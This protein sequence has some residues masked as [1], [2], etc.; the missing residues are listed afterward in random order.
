MKAVLSGG[1][2]GGALEQ[3][4]TTTSSVP[5]RTILSCGASKVETRAVTLSSP[6]R[7]AARQNCAEP[8][9]DRTET[10]INEEIIRLYIDLHKMGRAHS[11]EAWKDG[12]LVGG[13]YGVA[14]GAA[15]FGESMF[16]E[17]VDASKVA[18]VYLVA[19]LRKSGFRLLDSQFVTL[20][21]AQF[22]AVE[23]HRS[24]Y[25]QLLASALDVNA[26]FHCVLDD[27][28]SSWSCFFWRKYV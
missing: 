10:W 2:S 3:V 25:R 28:K 15:F 6:W 9:D 23:I 24:G 14:L 16:S 19:A 7:S 21:L 20:H 12:T 8:A 13:L 18:L 1:S 26:K 17:T 27:I 11:V 22:G 5:N 4:R